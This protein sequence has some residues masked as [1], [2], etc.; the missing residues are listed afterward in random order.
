MGYGAAPLLMDIHYLPPVQYF[1]HFA[2]APSVILEQWA[3]YIK[4][5]YGNRCVIAASGG[6]MV[7]SAPLLSGKYLQP[8]CEV[9]IAYHE[10]WQKRHW[11]SIHDAYRKAPFFEH[12]AE[13]IEGCFQHQR[14]FLAEWNLEL[15][16][17][18]LA[19][20]RIATP[21]SLTERFDPTP[22]SCTD[23]RKAIAFKPRL[24]RPDPQ[25]QVLPYVQVFQDRYSFIPNL[26][27]LDLLFCTGPEARAI[28][29]RSIT[30]TQ[31]NPT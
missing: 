7:L 18:L 4:G 14:E 6:P 23:L 25:F 3:P 21:Y 27:I 24:Q 22:D 2:N 30:T 29:R 26:S 9:R 16:R 19:C 28:L 13:R 1:A 10:P 20:L 17:V 15:L 11:R 31:N 5:T 8:F 12:Y